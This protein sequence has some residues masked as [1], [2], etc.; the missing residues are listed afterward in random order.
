MRGSPATREVQAP[1]FL[2]VRPLQRI[3]RS[4]YRPAGVV[5]A[6]EVDEGVGEEPAGVG[7]VERG[8]RF[9]EAV[10][11]TAV[12]VDDGG[13]RRRRPSRR[14]RA[15]PARARTAVPPAEVVVDVDDG[16]RG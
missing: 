13:A 4:I 15:L 3:A 11:P 5:D 8:E 1:R 12:E 2:F 16:E 6:F 10:A 14:G 9:L 7:L